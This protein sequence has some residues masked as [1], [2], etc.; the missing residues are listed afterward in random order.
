M[1][2]QPGNFGPVDRKPA[3]KNWLPYALGGAVALALVCAMGFVVFAFL[4]KPS[5]PQVINPT[6]TMNVVT[7]VTVA[8]EEP[9]DSSAEQPQ[10]QETPQPAENQPVV[11]EVTPASETSEQTETPAEPDTPPEPETQ[12]GLPLDQ[13]GICLA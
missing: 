6:P 7:F 11:E 3:G 9:V 12:S 13:T 1:H 5:Q 2:K 8:P 4:Y 10:P